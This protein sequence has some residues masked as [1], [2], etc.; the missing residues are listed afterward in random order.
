MAC[1]DM[2][3]NLSGWFKLI[4]LDL[5]NIS[6]SR[7]VEHTAHHPKVKG[8]SL[9]ASAGYGRGKRAEPKVIKL[10]TSVIYKGM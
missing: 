10:F 4:K 1:H 3:I 7:V 6:G 5:S 8:S 2:L 9:A